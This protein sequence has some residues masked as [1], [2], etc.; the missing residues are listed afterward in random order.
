MT[1]LMKLFLRLTKMNQ[2]TLQT[3][4]WLLLNILRKRWEKYYW[5]TLAKTKNIKICVKESHMQLKSFIKEQTSTQLKQQRYLTKFQSPQPPRMTIMMF[6]IMQVSLLQ[7]R[8]PKN[9]IWTQIYSWPKQKQDNLLWSGTSG[10]LPIQ[11]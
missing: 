1:L 3:V 2:M 5:I 9:K 6:R 10:R 4:W 8:S 11:P 7:R